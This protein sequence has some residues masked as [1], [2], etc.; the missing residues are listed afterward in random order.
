MRLKELHPSSLHLEGPKHTSFKC[1]LPLV[2]VLL[3]PPHAPF[4]LLPLASKATTQ[5]ESPTISPHRDFHCSLSRSVT[6]GGGSY[7]SADDA[8]CE[9]RGERACQARTELSTSVATALSKDKLP[10]TT[11]SKQKVAL[12]LRGQLQNP[13]LVFSPSLLVS[14]PRP[15]LPVPRSCLPPLP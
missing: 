12:I 1:N 14:L 8:D 10:S 15:P 5:Q 13:R 9:G 6:P 11:Q 7:A 2:A 3:V 4:L